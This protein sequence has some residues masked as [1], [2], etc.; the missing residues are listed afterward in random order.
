M[1]NLLRRTIAFTKPQMA[2]LKA[3][4]EELE[5]SVSDLVRRIIDEWRRK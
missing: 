2:A 5:I 4:A 3:K 1:E